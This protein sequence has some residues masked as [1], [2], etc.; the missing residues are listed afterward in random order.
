M[1]DLALTPAQIGEELREIARHP[2]S[3]KYDRDADARR[4]RDSAAHLRPAAAGERGG[5]QPPTSSRRSGGGCCGAW[6]HRISN[7]EQYIKLLQ[8]D[9][10]E[11]R[12]LFRIC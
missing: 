6:R 9:Q 11:L 10:V 7:T 8:A 2:Y 4:P 3:R 1:I 12:G 5:F